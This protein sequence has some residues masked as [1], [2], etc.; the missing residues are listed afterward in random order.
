MGMGLFIAWASAWILYKY[1]F[2]IISLRALQ[3]ILKSVFNTHSFLFLY[4][5]AVLYGGYKCFNY[6]NNYLNKPFFRSLLHWPGVY[7]DTPG[8]RT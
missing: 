7:H 2:E 1:I 4:V 8:Y 5:S 3:G 6:L